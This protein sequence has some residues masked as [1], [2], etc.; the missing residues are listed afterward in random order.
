MNEFIKKIEG[1]F[2]NLIHTGNVFHAYVFFGEDIAVIEDFAQRLAHVLEYGTFEK[3][4]RFLNDFLWVEP[5]DKESIGIDEVRAVQKFIYQKPTV[6]SK[7]MAVICP[8]DVVTGEGQSALLKLIEEPPKDA[9]IILI[10]HATGSLLQTI[11]SRVHEVY[12]PAMER[13]EGQDDFFT[14]AIGSLRRQLEKNGA[15]VHE[16]IRRK[17]AMDRYNLNK[18]LQMRLL[19]GYA[20]QYGLAKRPKTTAGETVKRKRKAK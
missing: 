12:F 17:M 16:I 19:E 11:G 20:G 13:E 3:D 1:D 18:P 5:T 2:K 7:R 4:D 8:A 10:A 6:S 9:L 15:L 14:E